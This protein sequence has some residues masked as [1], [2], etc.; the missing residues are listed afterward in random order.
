[1]SVVLDCKDG[2]ESLEQFKIQLPK[3][4]IEEIDRCYESQK[5]FRNPVIYV[6]KCL[7]FCNHF[8][9]TVASDVFDGNL[10]KLEYVYRKIVASNIKA[11]DILF[12]EVEDIDYDFG[13]VKSEF[14]QNEYS[15]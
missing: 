4:T 9:L 12:P 6:E 5:R 10:G 3:N 8:T 14:F 11:T 15:F 7:D 13:S 2:N 1:M